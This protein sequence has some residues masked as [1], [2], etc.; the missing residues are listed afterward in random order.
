MTQLN[1]AAKRDLARR[2]LISDTVLSLVGRAKGL[3]LLHFKEGLDKVTQFVAS[4]D[5]SN[6]VNELLQQGYEFA[7][8]E[9]KGLPVM[10]MD[11][12]DGLFYPLTGY[13]G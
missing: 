8:F 1:Q 10:R 2:G 7:G 9:Y 13:R 12:L 11:R 4:T 3:D 6:R 5:E